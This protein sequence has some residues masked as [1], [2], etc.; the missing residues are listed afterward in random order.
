MS[1]GHWYQSRSSVRPA[2]SEK[3]SDCTFS[4]GHLDKLQNNDK[5]HNKSN[6]KSNNNNNNNN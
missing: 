2:S 3:V 4:I 5:K 1:P 6:N